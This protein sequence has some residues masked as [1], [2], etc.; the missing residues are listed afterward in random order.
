MKTAALAAGDIVWLALIAA[1]FIC[2]VMSPSTHQS[3]GLTGES[4]G[5]RFAGKAGVVCFASAPGR[6]PANATPASALV[7]PGGP[8]RRRPNRMTERKSGAGLLPLPVAS[9]P[10][11]PGRLPTLEMKPA[12][13]ALRPHRRPQRGRRSVRPGEASSPP[14]PPQGAGG[15]TRPRPAWP[16]GVRLADYFR[17]RLGPSASGFT[18]NVP[19]VM[20]V[21]TYSLSSR[22]MR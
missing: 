1:L 22:V 3:L 21:V 8:A 9:E 14:L 13:A 7:G 2:W 18:K 17:L 16:L 20:D 6:S 11:L 5:C 15:A 19:S 12:R 10:S 4:P